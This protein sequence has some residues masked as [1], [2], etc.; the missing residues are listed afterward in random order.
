[1]SDGRLKNYYGH[2]LI[3]IF[4]LF[5]VDGVLPQLQMALF[6]GRILF[7][8]ILV[9]GV[10][11]L[12]LAACLFLHVYR[13]GKVKWPRRIK[14]EYFIFLTY[15]VGHFLLLLGE[16]PLDYLLFTYNAYYFF[17]LILPFTIYAP[18]DPKTFLRWLIIISIPAL[19]LGIAQF[20][21]GSPIL[22]V[23][24]A[25]NLFDVAA[26]RY[27]GK[28][29]AFSLFTSGLQFGYFLTLLEAVLIYYL[30]KRK[31]LRRI[32]V[33]AALVVV[34]FAC[35]S[36]LTRNTYLQFV[37]TGC[38]A[39]LLLAQ[40]AGF[41]PLLARFLGV[42]PAIYGVVA[43]ISV[44]GAQINLLGKSQTATIL[45]DESLLIRLLGWHRHYQ[46]WTE[47]GLAKLLFGVGMI[48]GGRFAIFGEVV[49]IDNSF[50]SVGLHIGLIG[51]GLWVFFMWR[52]WLWMLNV[53]R[54]APDNVAL[55]AIAAFWS[56]WISSGLFNDTFI[57]YSMLSMI[58][59]PL[60]LG[61]KQTFGLTSRQKPSLRQ[62]IIG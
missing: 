37:F 48:G 54:N 52:L 41:S 19:S 33:L 8:N 35:Y 55:F 44:V 4:F 23:S 15:L 56:T 39:L 24:S 30:F 49:I 9:K 46:L 28:V 21:S 61:N 3:I 50:L 7:P 60:C 26:W 31:G 17:I 59:L 27:Y 5:L 6:S 62:E 47:S 18:I 14:T 42:I 58:V 45:R 36:T 34:S 16:Y 12:L 40:K 53:L 2:I 22:P 10:L 38:T 11:I 29:R 25:D 51:L 20:V 13:T 1:M 32:A 57:L 43:F